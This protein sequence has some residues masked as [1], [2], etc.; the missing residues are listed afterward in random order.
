VWMVFVMMVCCGFLVGLLCIVVCDWWVI[1]F[2]EFE[3]WLVGNV[4]VYYYWMM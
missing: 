2:V 1:W 3:V 4:V